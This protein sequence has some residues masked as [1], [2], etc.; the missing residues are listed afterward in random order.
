MLAGSSRGRQVRIRTRHLKGCFATQSSRCQL[1]QGIVYSFKIPWEPISEYP[2]GNADAMVREAISEIPAGHPL[3]GR[4]L[5]TLARR[6][7]GDD[8]LFLLDGGPEVA[9]AH[10]TWSGRRESGDFPRTQL[11]SSISEFI[12]TRMESDHIEFG[13]D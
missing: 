12:S 9:V 4:K 1:G 6:G 10:L 7:D 3:A 11:F 8:V 2:S 13:D 5:E